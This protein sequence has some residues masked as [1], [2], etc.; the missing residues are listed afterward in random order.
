MLKG[1]E[2]TVPAV[3]GAIAHS[4][5][6][7]SASSGG[8]SEP[9]ATQPMGE[10]GG[11]S[12]D[13]VI[14]AVPGD[15][16][17][18]ALLSDFEAPVML[19]DD[20]LRLVRQSPTAKRYLEGRGLDP[21]NVRLPETMAPGVSKERLPLIRQAMSQ[22]QP[23][24][25]LGM[26]GGVWTRSAYRPFTCSHGKTF[27]VVSLVPVVETALVETSGIRPMVY[28]ARVDDLGALSV[29]TE[30]EVEVLRLIGL[31]LSSEDIASVLHRS[32]KTV[33]GH[34]V[35]LGNKMRITN[36]VELARI[37]LQSGITKMD[38]DALVL[39]WR[40]AKLLHD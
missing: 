20:A 4:A 15:V 26:L 9:S 29:L 24:Y 6:S 18:E 1:H 27:V 38:G 40:Q 23:L 25:V 10:A 3:L 14:P 22:L 36:R 17:L 30:R 34:R 12:G 39:L 16:L 8:A 28:R 7:E 35:A 19:Y 31:G 33:Q 2:Q 37:A 32:V 5:G 21:G 11:S 13:K